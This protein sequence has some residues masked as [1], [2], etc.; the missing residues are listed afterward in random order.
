MITSLA[1]V[2][3]GDTN[4][5]ARC[6]GQLETTLP[7]PVAKLSPGNNSW[8]H[9]HPRPLPRYHNVTFENGKRVFTPGGQNGRL[10][11][12]RVCVFYFILLSFA[13]LVF[14]LLFFNIEKKT[15]HGD[16][17][18][19]LMGPRRDEATCAFGTGLE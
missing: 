6:Q 10:G 2:S 19:Y 16:P 18:I 11:G 15:P 9:H 1:K 3:P 12:G 7:T 13:L 17:W 4:P 8:K 14:S 5:R